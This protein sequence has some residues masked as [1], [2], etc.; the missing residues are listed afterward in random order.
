MDQSAEIRILFVSADW[1]RKNGDLV[2]AVCRGLLKAGITLRLILVGD[3]PEH[4]KHLD[5]VDDLGFLRKS[6]PPQMS[7]LCRAY[8]DAHFLLLPTT[9]EAFG[10]VF[11]EAQA[12]GLPSIAYD[13]GG[14]G[15]AIIQG[16]TGSLLPIGAT[17]VSFVDEL[18]RSF[19]APVSYLERC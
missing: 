18:M 14:V 13:V 9:A 4:A 2:I 3:T 12:F 11:S 10:I 19:R 15:S 7:T 16:Q 1:R 17:E 5:F 8:R 6:D